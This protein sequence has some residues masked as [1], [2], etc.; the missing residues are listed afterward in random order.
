M[1][2]SSERICEWFEPDFT[3]KKNEDVNANINCCKTLIALGKTMW[4]EL[5]GGEGKRKWIS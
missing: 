5:R 4:N 1:A 3:N 2:L